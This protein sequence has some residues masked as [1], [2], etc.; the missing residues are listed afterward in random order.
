M[1]TYEIVLL[2]IG[3]FI[4]LLI[5]WFLVIHFIKRN[6]QNHLTKINI[7]DFPTSDNYKKLE[8]NKDKII[9]KF[10]SVEVLIANMNKVYESTYVSSPRILGFRFNK[11]QREGGLRV[12]WSKLDKGELTLEK[13]RFQLEGSNS[14]RTFSLKSIAKVKVISLNEL[15]IHFYKKVLYWKLRFQTSEELILF[16]NYFYSINNYAKEN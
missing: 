4:L 7:I 6:D 11:G 2:A 9:H 15:A 16:L 5:V 1:K 13:T 8:I 12:T 14:H 3:L 10:F